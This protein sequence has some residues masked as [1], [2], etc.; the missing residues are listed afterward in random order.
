MRLP[1]H[2]P[3][4]S[5]L[6]LGVDHAGRLAW[7]DHAH[8]ARDAHARE[9]A[10]PADLPLV[11][12]VR[13]ENNALAPTTGPAPVAGEPVFV[14]PALMHV[15]AAL[16]LGADALGVIAAVAHAR[17]LDAAYDAERRKIPVGLPRTVIGTIH[18]RFRRVD[19]PPMSFTHRRIP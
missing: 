1:A 17:D 2:T 12:I 7:L 4:G 6:V 10:A 18:A 3:I 9:P 11:C 14:Q 5:H 13:V 19:D 15:D 8:F 16:V